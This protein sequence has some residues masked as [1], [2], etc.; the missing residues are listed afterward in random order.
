MQVPKQCDHNIDLFALFMFLHSEPFAPFKW[1][2]P[3][4]EH[5]KAKSQRTEK[6]VFLFNFR[7]LIFDQ[8]SSIH[9]V[10][11]SRELSL[12]VTKEKYEGGQIL[13]LILDNSFNCSV[14]IIYKF[15]YSKLISLNTNNSLQNQ[16]KSTSLSP[17]EGGGQ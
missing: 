14:V 1:E 13:C 2:Q 10:S 7:T 17:G 15:A 5:Y 11:K 8:K 4:D 12:T 16:S 3:E 9:K 6:I